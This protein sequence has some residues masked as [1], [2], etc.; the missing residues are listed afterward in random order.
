M[1]EILL[2]LY[3]FSEKNLPN[4][5]HKRLLHIYYFFM[6]CYFKKFG[7]KYKPAETTK[8]KQRRLKENFFK[9]YCNG[10]GIDIGYGGDLVVENTIGW[11]YENGDAQYLTEIDDERYDF[12]YTSHV[13]EH[14]I[15]AKVALQNWW[16]VLKKNGYLLLYLPHRELYE[17]KKTLPSN[18]NPD[19]KHFFVENNH[20][21]PHT[22]GLRQ[23]IK[24]T[25]TGYE[26]IYVKV[27]DEGHTITD[28]NIHSDGE[29]SIEAVI[30]KIN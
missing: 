25:L 29:Y 16:R 13:I 20:E 17:K 2:R 1:S 21:P 5:L 7:R 3:N 6:K 23:L 19:H 4:S 30:R 26:I 12:V 9:K 15:D 22:L 28:P 24:E 11:D 8:A 14:M 18:W 27:C 10:E